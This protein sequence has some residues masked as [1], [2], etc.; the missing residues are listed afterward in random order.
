MATEPRC[1]PLQPVA[2]WGWSSGLHSGAHL[3][4]TMQSILHVPPPFSKSWRKMR[5]FTSF[6]LSS[7]L[8]F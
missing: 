5:H 6:G 2:P 3:G 7:L 4:T 8:A 1:V